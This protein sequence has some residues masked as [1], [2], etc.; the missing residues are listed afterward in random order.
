MTFS[1]HSKGA[2][3]DSQIPIVL[4]FAARRCR[5]PAGAEPSAPNRLA[6][7]GFGRVKGRPQGDERSELALEAAKSLCDSPTDSR[8]EP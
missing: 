4:R 2:E 7:Q 1:L 6:A 3:F 5:L 8:E